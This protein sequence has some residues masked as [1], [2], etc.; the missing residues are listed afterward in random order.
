MRSLILS[1]FLVLISS[2]GVASAANCGYSPGKNRCL[3]D[4][5]CDCKVTIDELTYFVNAANYSG[6]AC[7]DFACQDDKKLSHGDLD[8]GFTITIN[9]LTQMVNNANLTNGCPKPCYSGF[10]YP[11]GIQGNL[12]K[13]ETFKH[14]RCSECGSACKSC[15]F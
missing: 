6:P 2:T 9:E 14:L 5:N 4:I 12:C 10:D 13:H 1:I 3:G 8:C 11:L 7:Q 15:G